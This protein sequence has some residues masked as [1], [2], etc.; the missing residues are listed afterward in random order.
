M[1][2]TV[3]PFRNNVYFRKCKG[4]ALASLPK[5]FTVRRSRLTGKGVSLLQSATLHRRETGE[6]RCLGFRHGGRAPYWFER[7]KRRHP[8]DGACHR[9]SFDFFA[10]RF[11]HEARVEMQPHIYDWQCTMEVKLWGSRSGHQYAETTDGGEVCFLVQP[12]HLL[13]PPFSFHRLPWVTALID[14]AQQWRRFS[15]SE[16]DDIPPSAAVACDGH[17]RRQ[18]RA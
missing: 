10:I 6:C 16:V 18:L 5:P 17:R 3:D 11:G 12:K 2:C 8:S 14:E 7:E 1:G 13:S 4:E 9:D 15:S